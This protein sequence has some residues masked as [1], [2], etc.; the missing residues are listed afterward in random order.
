MAARKDRNDLQ[1]EVREV[2]KHFWRT[3][4]LQAKA[5]GQKSRKLDVGARSAAT[6]GMQLA[7][8]A[9]LFRELP[10]E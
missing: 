2:I 5:Q 4:D 10:V 9:I 8:F 6:G 3:R 1:S 7:G